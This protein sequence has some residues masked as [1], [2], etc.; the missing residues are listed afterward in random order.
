M[1]GPFIFLDHMGPSEGES[2]DEKEG[3]QI[4]LWGRTSF[5]ALTQLLIG[6][7]FEYFS[8]GDTKVDGN[9]IDDSDSNYMNIMPMVGYQLSSGKNR[10]NI[11]GG[12]L[13]HI[14]GKNF[15]KFYGFLIST[16]IFV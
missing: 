2:W 13:L 4:H 11:T 14:N 5:K 12:Y 16:F 7:D 1:G 3:N 6:L 8:K 9:T 15:P 10:V